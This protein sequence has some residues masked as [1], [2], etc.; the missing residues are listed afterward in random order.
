MPWREGEVFL[1]GTAME[2][3]SG[4]AGDESPHGGKICKTRAY[5]RFRRG[6]PE[7]IT[8]FLPPLSSPLPGELQQQRAL[9]E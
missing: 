5:T 9:E 1:L 3:S 4:V 2:L 6:V 7:A 8:T